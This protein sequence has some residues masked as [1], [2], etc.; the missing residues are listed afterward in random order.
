MPKTISLSKAIEQV[1]AAITEAAADLDTDPD[2]V[3]YDVVNA[4]L[5]TEDWP[6][7]VKADVRRMVL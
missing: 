6:Q 4:V 5:A 1:E 7:S 3:A 2:T